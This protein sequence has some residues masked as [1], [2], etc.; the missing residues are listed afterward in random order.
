MV[1]SADEELEEASPEAEEVEKAAKEELKEFRWLDAVFDVL[2]V[3]FASPWKRVPRTGQR[4]SCR[5][6]VSGA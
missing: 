4:C 6:G 3:F 5:G 1:S 2:K